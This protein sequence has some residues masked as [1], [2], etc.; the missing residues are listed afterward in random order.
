[1]VGTHL[2]H[3]GAEDLGRHGIKVVG[4]VLHEAGAARQ[5]AGHDLDQTNHDRRLPVAL[6]AETE[7]SAI[8]PLD[9]YA[10]Q[11]REPV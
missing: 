2:E 9:A 11:L 10:G 6:G 5:S 3:V 1:M 8:S 7:P 4:V